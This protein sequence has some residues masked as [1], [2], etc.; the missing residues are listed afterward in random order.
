MAL[1]TGTFYT[2]GTNSCFSNLLSPFFC[3]SLVRMKKTRLVSSPFRR[4][5]VPDGWTQ[6]YIW[7][8]QVSKFGPLSSTLQTLPGGALGG[9]LFTSPDFVWRMLTAAVN[10]RAWCWSKRTGWSVTGS[11]LG[12]GSTCWCIPNWG[13]CSISCCWG[14]SCGCLRGGGWPGW[15]PT[16]TCVGCRGPSDNTSWFAAANLSCSDDA[17]IGISQGTSLVIVNIW[18]L[19]WTW[20][21]LI[22]ALI[23]VGPHLGNLVSIWGIWSPWEPNFLNFPIFSILQR[24]ESQSNHYLMLTV[25]F[26]VMTKTSY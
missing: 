22:L 2:T 23:E 6:L 26:L 9:N 8:F 4:G 18:N 3:F 19:V 7:L 10:W 15:R 5:W 24:A 21:S 17:N 12:A 1:N 16:G 20:Y 11:K 13:C 25:L 14:G